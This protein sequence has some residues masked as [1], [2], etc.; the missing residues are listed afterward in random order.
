MAQTQT[1]F[2]T[3]GTGF[4]GLN[5]VE[6]LTQ[7]GW[8]VVALHRR[9]SNLNYLK[10]FDVDL[11]EGAVEDRS[12]LER[13][14]PQGVDAVF[15]V[16]A[17]VSFWS[18]NNLR[19]TQCNVDGTRNMVAAA[20]ARG[21]RKFIHTSTSGVYGLQRQPFDETAPKLGRDFWVNYMR[22]KA[23]A[24]E[25]VLSGIERGLDAVMLNPANIVGRYDVQGWARLMRLALE[26][27]LPRV[28]PGSSSFCH[29]SEV[30]RAHIAAVARGRKGANY[31]LGGPDARYVELLTTLGEVAG[32]AIRA[33]TAPK[34]AVRFA[35]RIG[36]LIARFTKREPMITLEGAAYLCSNL[37]CRCDRAVAELGYAIVPLRAMVEDWYRWSL[38]EG[39]IARRA[40]SHQP[41][42]S[43]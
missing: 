12:S 37:I 19:Q 4:L 43:A 29:A 9:Q 17:D 32:Q 34:P 39:L 41:A 8:R 7:A 6:Q 5:L 21:A 22:T 15:H 18:R 20:L 30:A 26:A 35:A 36:G 38:A 42:Q 3:G 25:E 2:V 16:A 23:Q 40:D 27:R 10:R 1:A 31:L 24:E 28:P 14:L 13:A 33:R 11:V